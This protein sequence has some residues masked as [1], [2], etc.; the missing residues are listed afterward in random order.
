MSKQRT[1]RT[2]PGGLKIHETLTTNPEFPLDQFARE[3]DYLEAL[4]W[5]LLFIEYPED[6]LRATTKVIEW[7]A[8]FRV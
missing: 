2:C 5:A 3:L 6:N 1:R 4:D 8:G 7:P